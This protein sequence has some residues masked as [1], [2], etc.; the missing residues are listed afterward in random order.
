[1]DLDFAEFNSVANPGADAD[2]HLIVQFFHKV[3]PNEARSRAEGR[4]MFDEIEYIK[5]IQPGSRFP[6]FE[7]PVR[8]RDKPRFAR[9]YQAFLQKR[10]TAPEGT[11]LEEWP[12]ISRSLAEEYKSLSV[13]TVEQLAALTDSGL[14]RIMGSRDLQKKAKA[15]LAQAKDGALVQRLSVENDEQKAEL[16][17]L[18]AQVKD[19]DDEVKRLRKDKK[20]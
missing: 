20:S 14:S 6:L 1:M 13:F 9:Q 2:K 3:V 4:A 10:A 8:E 19:L 11:P 15:W 17:R 12:M 5:I 18:R 7:G 16:E